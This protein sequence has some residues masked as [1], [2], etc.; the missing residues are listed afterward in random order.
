MLYMPVEN[1]SSRD[2]RTQVYVTFMMFSKCFYQDNKVLT[3][4]HF[5]TFRAIASPKTLNVYLQE[6][7][8]EHFLSQE[9]ENNYYR[10]YYGHSES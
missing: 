1:V 10:L 6:F 8:T 7:L 9:K 2:G 3:Y 4:F 5:G